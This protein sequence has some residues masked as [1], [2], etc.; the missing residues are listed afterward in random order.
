MN[1][2]I[3]FGFK[4]KFGKVNLRE[5]EK[6]NSF[7]CYNIRELIIESHKFQYFSNLAISPR[8][9]YVVM[10]EKSILLQL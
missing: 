1:I 9:S 7:I 8:I 10:R 2:I 3:L 5:K 6:I 4:D